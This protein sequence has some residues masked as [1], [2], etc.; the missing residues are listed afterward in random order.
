MIELTQKKVELRGREDGDQITVA[1]HL[2]FFLLELMWI[3]LH[4]LQS[5]VSLVAQ[6]VQETQVWPLS[7]EDT[8]EKGIAIHSSILA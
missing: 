4:Y 3:N 7:W 5:G 2:F 6:I 8:L 1:K